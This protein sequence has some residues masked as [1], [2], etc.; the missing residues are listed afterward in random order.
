MKA[1]LFDVDGVLNNMEN[2]KISKPEI[3]VHLVG[4]LQKGSPIGF[5]SGRGLLWHSDGPD[6]ITHYKNLR[7]DKLLEDGRKTV[8]VA[9]RKAIYND[10]QKYLLEDAPAVFLYYPDEYTITRN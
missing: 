3:I 5:I 2:R 4:L 9:K 1:Y 7:I 10:F 6:N 8:D